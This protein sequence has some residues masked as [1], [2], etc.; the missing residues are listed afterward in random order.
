[1]EQNNKSKQFEMELAKSKAE[2]TAEELKQFAG[3]EDIELSMDK[4]ENVSGGWENVINAKYLGDK[5]DCYW[6]D[7]L[8]YCQHCGSKNGGVEVEE[9][10]YWF[11]WKCFDCKRISHTGVIHVI[12]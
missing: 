5:D 8:R 7:E 9:N 1:M 12:E 10:H 4:L 2:K 11:R 3:E 6:S